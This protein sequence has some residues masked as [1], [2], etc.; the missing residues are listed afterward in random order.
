MTKNMYIQPSVNITE[1]EMIQALCVSGGGNTPDPGV[2]L[3]TF[4]PGATTDIQLQARRI[5]QRSVVN[6][7]TLQLIATCIQGKGIH[8]SV[9]ACFFFVLHW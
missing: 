2:P 3:S 1:M 6:G 4:S 5:Y 9:L 8:P 7:S